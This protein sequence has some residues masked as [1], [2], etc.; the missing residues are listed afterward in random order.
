M[1]ITRDDL[2]AASQ[3]NLLSADQADDLWAWL[4]QRKSRQ[5]VGIQILAYLGA[6]VVISSL[7]WFATKAFS[8]S[9]PAILLVTGLVY[10]IGF[11]VAGLYAR[12]L[13]SPI[14]PMLLLTIAVFMVPLTIYAFQ[15]VLGLGSFEGWGSYH[16]FYVWI[17]RGWFPIELGTLVAALAALAL[18]R[19][20]FLT[21]PLAF[22]L[23]FL[24]MDL[25]PLIFGRDFN[26]DERR[27][28][29]ML[30]GLGMLAVSY[31]LDLR[32]KG[33]D[34]SFWL[35]FFGLLAFWG[36]LSLSS[37]DELGPKLLYCGINLLL[38]VVSML[39]K[40][41]VFLVF[42]AVGVFGF[43]Y[44]ITQNVFRNS[45]FFPLVLSLVGM[46]ILASAIVLLKRQKA[47]EAF[48]ERHVSSSLRKWLPRRKI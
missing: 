26:W 24:S 33:R 43:L 40:R 19:Y 48:F 21:F 7:T 13:E 27:L 5:S 35:Y 11:T 32:R 45:L 17:S 23:W 44:D 42:G 38:I 22:V 10:F 9:N 46:A 28:V 31:A 36:A 25:I 6:L 41:P 18:F 39:L 4:Q 8:E 37:T 1:K 12:R 14:P 20:E 29:S 34:Y 16:D 3:E 2:E 47:I 30:F 15:K